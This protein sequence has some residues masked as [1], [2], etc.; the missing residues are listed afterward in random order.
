[1]EKLEL[2]PAVSTLSAQWLSPP[3]PGAGPAPSCWSRS[4][5]GQA[6]A[7]SSPF[8]VCVFPFLPTRGFLFQRKRLLKRV[9][10]VYSDHS[11]VCSLASKACH[12]SLFS[13]AV[14]T[15]DLVLGCSMEWVGAGC[16]LFLAGACSKVV[17]GIPAAKV[18]VRNL[19]AS[20]AVEYAPTMAALLISQFS[21]KRSAFTE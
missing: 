5:E 19:A 11:S 21:L 17:L 14:A 16:S 8:E 3:L 20:G 2:E 4:P 1:M 12:T 6:W 15:R 10:L 9:G 13:V 18:A 7:D